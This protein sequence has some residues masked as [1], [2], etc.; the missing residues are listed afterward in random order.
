MI[1]RKVEQLIEERL[2]D[3][4]VILIL[5]PR[6][7]GKT[8]LIHHLFENQNVLFLNGD[9]A[10]NRNVLSNSDLPMLKRIVGNFSY[11][12]IDEAQRIDGVGLLMKQ[13]HDEMTQVKVVATG[14]SSLL[15][16]DQSKE[17]LTG[18][19]WE[20][21]MFPVSFS[22]MADHHGFLSELKMLS[23]RM[24]YGYY[25]DV[26]LHP[27][28]AKDILKELSDSY[29]YKDLLS[30]GVIKKP[31]AVEKLIQALAWQ[32]GSEVNF[33]ELGQ[34]TGIHPAT[35]EEYL[36]LLEKM[37]VVFRL[38]SYSRNLRNEIKKGKKYYFY[39]LGI[40]NAV[41]NNFN[42]LDARNDVGALWENFVILERKKHKAYQ[43]IW[44]NDYFWRTHAQQEIDYLEEREGKLF[45]YEIKWNPKKK[46]K[47]SKSF[48]QSYPEH[49]FQVI[50][51]DNFFEFVG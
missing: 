32:L 20:F 50:S 11:V 30:L 38:S 3:K 41:I 8:T 19:K 39:D 4:K 51:R 43:R 15:L 25:P 40:R 26:V 10:Q 24:I 34:V 12:V 22:E 2:S 13:L 21:R 44:S 35:V 37:F 45:A 31:K 33:H 9:D 28:D 46:A 29:L 18:R 48:I 1:R 17:P 42:E 5:G 47:L 49:E 36:D 6:Q 27:N 14:S 16:S 7:V 23:Q